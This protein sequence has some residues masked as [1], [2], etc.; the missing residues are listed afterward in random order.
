MKTYWGVEVQLHAFLDLSTRW[1]WVVSFTP[2]VKATA[3]HWIGRWVSSR[4][5]LGAVVKRKI[6]NPRRESNHRTPIVQTVVQRYTDWAI[7]ALTIS[8]WCQ[9]ELV[10]LTMRLKPLLRRTRWFALCSSISVSQWPDWR[11]LT[12]HSQQCSNSTQRISKDMLLVCTVVT[13]YFR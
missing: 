7:A 9:P 5:L 2:R 13:H 10:L 12:S 11:A 3:T 8:Y 1:R 6:P 4:A